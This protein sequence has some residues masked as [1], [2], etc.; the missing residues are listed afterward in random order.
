MSGRT[1]SGFFLAAAISFLPTSALADTIM[2]LTLAGNFDI[3]LSGT[4]LSTLDDGNGATPGDQ[5]TK[6]E[7]PENSF[8]FGQDGIEDVVGSFTLSGIELTGSPFVV[9]GSLL[10]YQTTGGTFEVYDDAG[11]P[12]L[13][14]SLADGSFYGTIGTGSAAT[15]GWLTVNL[16]TFTGPAAPNDALFKLLDP[17]SAA[18]SI[19]FTELFTGASPGVAVVDGVLQDFTADATANIAAESIN[20]S[21]VPEP[22]AIGLCL[23]GALSILSLR[24]RQR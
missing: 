14:G 2:N 15:G 13:T 18:M 5:D 9:G 17:D 23:F 8:V 12:I 3:E 4:E 7:F 21:L 19:S 22:N 1:L 10:T 20:N 24:L 6:I 11:L 16:G